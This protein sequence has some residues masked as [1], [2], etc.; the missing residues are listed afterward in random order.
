MQARPPHVD[1]LQVAKFVSVPMIHEHTDSE[2]DPMGSV[3]R[4]RE[5]GSV[6]GACSSHSTISGTTA[7]VRTSCLLMDPS[8]SDER[9]LSG[10]LLELDVKT[11]LDAISICDHRLEEKK[12]DTQG[13]SRESV[14]T[15]E[16]LLKG[17][18]EPHTVSATSIESAQAMLK[19]E[20]E[21]PM[22]TAES[23]E[24]DQKVLK[25][26][27][28]SSTAIARILEID[29][30]MPE[31]K[32][33]ILTDFAK[34]VETAKEVVG[35]EAETLTALSSTE[36]ETAVSDYIYSE[37]SLPPS[38]TNVEIEFD[39]ISEASLCTAVSGSVSWHSMPRSETEVERM[40][41]VRIGLYKVTDQ[42]CSS[43]ANTLR[44]RY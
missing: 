14:E 15:A 44:G 21:P 6:A 30:E 32:V 29:Q 3:S 8:D 7:L 19:E 40:Y 1:G 39:V 18:A 31:E 43:T 42:I 9:Y 38:E 36:L 17:G 25:K 12:I 20:A 13:E 41:D 11:A 35:E 26:E 10:D 5:N 37:Y 2:E 16:A 33:E 4:D 24:A 23:A 27:V 22:A 28:E 34:S